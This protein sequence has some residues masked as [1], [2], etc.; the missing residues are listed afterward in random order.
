MSIAF[1]E[2][3]P[4]S[5]CKSTICGTVSLIF[6]VLAIILPVVIMTCFQHKA[7]EIQ[8]IRAQNPS[9]LIDVDLTAVMVAFEGY[10]YA[11]I[12]TTATS[13]IGVLTGAVSLIRRERSMWQPIV[14][15]IVNVPMFALAGYSF[16]LILIGR[17]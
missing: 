3:S 2:Q 16:F 13:L 17:S 12:V 8:R 6:A 7:A 5:E 4:V 9:K 15:L 14:G 11:V 1:L 10:T